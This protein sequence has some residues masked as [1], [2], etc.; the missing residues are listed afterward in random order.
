MSTSQ[1]LATLQDLLALLEIYGADR[2]R[3]P[4]DVRVRLSPLIAS[5]ARAQQA[6]NE[7][8]ALD[9]LLDLAPQISAQSER[10]LAARIV[11][12]ALGQQATAARPNVRN[13]HGGRRANLGKPQFAVPG[14][15]RRQVGGALLAASLVLGIFAG[16]TG[17]ASSTFDGVAEVLGLSDE[18]PEF[19]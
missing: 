19:A 3:W 4:A 10:A 11:T 9:A 2:S 15:F 13:W 8:A 17:Q 16:V 14:S 12:A 1:P 6:V 7:A 18:E 5:D